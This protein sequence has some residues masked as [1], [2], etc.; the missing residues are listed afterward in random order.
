M[1][2]SWDFLEIPLRRDPTP[3]VDFSGA[4]FSVEHPS[5]LRPV[6]FELQSAVEFQARSSV[7]ALT[8]SILQLLP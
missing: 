2:A 7:S 1:T 5:G 8:H 4:P 6:E 3:G